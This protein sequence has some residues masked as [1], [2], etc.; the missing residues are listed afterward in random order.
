MFSFHISSAFGTII[1]LLFIL[2][3]LFTFGII[4][5]TA[6]RGLTQYKRNN[7]SPVLTVDAK[8][9]S[10]RADVTRHHHRAGADSTIHYTTSS[11]RY[12]VTFEVPSGDRM[13]FHL[14]DSEYGLLA[15]GDEGAL[16]FQGTRYLSFTRNR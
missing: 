13:E 2:M 8:V 15:E 14:P 16:T 3:F 9:V 12:Y 7:A 5:V 1:P 11:T 6:V 4:I 10:K